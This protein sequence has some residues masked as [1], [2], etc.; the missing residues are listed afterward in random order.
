MAVDFRL[1]PAER[2]GT[3]KDPY[4]RLIPHPAR[5][6][7]SP[8][9]SATALVRHSRRAE[10]YPETR[11]DTRDHSRRAAAVASP[12]QA[13]AWRFLPVTKSLLQGKRAIVAASCLRSAQ[14][15][16]GRGRRENPAREG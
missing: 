7:A 12:A 2:Q 4:G 15:L 9:I 13:R 16:F 8:V 6:P 10:V 11:I 5:F 1:P 14:F 3:R